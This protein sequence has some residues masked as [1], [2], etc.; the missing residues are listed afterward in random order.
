MTHLPH[1]SQTTPSARPGLFISPS[2]AAAVVDDPA[3]V[4]HEERLLWPVGGRSPLPF[5]VPWEIYEDDNN[6]SSRPRRR[7]RYRTWS[8]P[9]LDS[10]Q[11]WKYR[12]GSSLCKSEKDAS[13][14]NARY[15]LHVI[16][17]AR[18]ILQHP[19]MSLTTITK[20]TGSRGAVGASPRCLSGRDGAGIVR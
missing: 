8:I 9:S 6:Q 17:S 15:R 5:T 2:A 19:P 13:P 14:S 3:W 16:S 11:L 18:V 12:T 10:R 1:T 7:R 4:R 20:A